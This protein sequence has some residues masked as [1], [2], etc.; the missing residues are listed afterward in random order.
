MV[1]VSVIAGNSE[2]GETVCTATTGMLK[3]MVSAPSLLLASIMACLSEPAP[4]S[5]ALVTV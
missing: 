1:S 5:R 2:V 4:E 3:L